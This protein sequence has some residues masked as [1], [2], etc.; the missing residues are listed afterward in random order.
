M[1][2]MIVYGT[3]CAKCKKLYELTD[4][5]SKEL[6]VEYSLNKVEDMMQI[7]EAGVMVTPALKINGKAVVSGSLPSEADLTKIITSVK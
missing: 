2:E 6:G 1:L 7:V 3:G 4:K 5:V